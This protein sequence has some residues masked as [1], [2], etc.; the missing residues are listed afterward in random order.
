MQ[1]PEFEREHPKP[2]DKGNQIAHR[3]DTPVAPIVNIID[4]MPGHKLNDCNDQAPKNVVD[5]KWPP[6][7]GPGRCPRKIKQIVPKFTISSCHRCLP[8]E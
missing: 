1:A 4:W 6:K 7:F 3:V 8:P 5:N 2:D